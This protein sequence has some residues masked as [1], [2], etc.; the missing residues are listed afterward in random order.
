[1]ILPSYPRRN[2]TRT[3]HGGGRHDTTKGCYGIFILVALALFFILRLSS[4]SSSSSM[5]P[6]NPAAAQK[7]IDQ[8]MDHICSALDAFHSLYR[9]P[10]SFQDPFSFLGLDL[11]APP[12]NPP[13]YSAYL[14][15]AN[16]K[17]VYKAVA[18]AV[19]R[20]REPVWAL[21]LGKAVWLTHTHDRKRDLV[22]QKTYL[23]WDTGSMGG[24][25]CELKNMASKG[26]GVDKSKAARELYRFRS[27]V[28]EHDPGS[29]KLQLLNEVD[30]GYKYLESLG[31][32]KVPDEETEEGWQASWDKGQEGVGLLTLHLIDKDDSG[33]QG[34]SRAKE[35]E[36][37]GPLVTT[38]SAEKTRKMRD[39]YRWYRS[40]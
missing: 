2:I 7:E 40:V 39:F 36:A 1:M 10:T 27:G 14:G 28:L 16:H 34:P 19:L 8:E 13:E 22:K 15:A 12:F 37:D 25:T 26:G 4:P 35:E 20:M 32:D 9:R 6:T 30:P 18:A 17:A 29:K 31:W 21:Y 11:R 5:T 3:P 38:W 24:L 23:G 33:V